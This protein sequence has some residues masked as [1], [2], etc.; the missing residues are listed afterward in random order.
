M[1][2]M[3]SAWR[4][5]SA[6]V[7]AIMDAAQLNSALACQ[8]ADQFTARN[9]YFLMPAFR[10]AWN[11]I[12][13]F[14]GT[15]RE[16]LPPRATQIVDDYQ[17]IMQQLVINKTATP[18]GLL[19]IINAVC[20]ARSRLDFVLAGSDEPL[21]RVVERAF[22][23]LQRLIVVDAEAARKW[24]DAFAGSRA[25]EACERL[26]ATHLLLHGVWA[27]KA[28]SEKERTDLVLGTAVDTNE[29]ERTADAMVLTEW[30]IAR[31]ESDV[32]SQADQARRQ[33]RVYSGSG[34]AGFELSW[35][36]YV[37]IV[38]SDR[39]PMPSDQRDGDILYRVVNV[40][41]NPSTPSKLRPTSST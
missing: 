9:D 2:G 40:A 19:D 4:A 11:Q 17:R 37:V 22:V 6:Y 26:G 27:F 39:L 16:F 8:P 12:L 20:A 34:L 7:Q 5:I 23:H 3:R 32:T 15:Y 29:A 31:S 18:A 1:Q 35:V 13:N 41:V 30:K 28:Y 25:E 21:K 36:R 24:Q 33:A 10:D 38:T 14:C